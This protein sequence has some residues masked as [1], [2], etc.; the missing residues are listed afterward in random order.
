MK[1]QK[2][3]VTEMPCGDTI[4]CVLPLPGLSGHPWFE[5]LVNPE[6]EAL[7]DG[8]SWLFKFSKWSIAADTTWR[9]FQGVS[10]LANNTMT[11]HCANDETTHVRQTDACNA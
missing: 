1:R 9:Y 6:G 5:K 3:C 7:S 8:A 10:S 4:L 11:A 2:M